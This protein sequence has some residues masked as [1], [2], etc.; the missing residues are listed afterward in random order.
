EALGAHRSEEPLCAHADTSGA[1][2]VEAADQ[3]DPARVVDVALVPV[4]RRDIGARGEW[5]IAHKDAGTCLPG[6]AR[7]DVLHEDALPAAVLALGGGKRIA[8]VER[9]LQVVGLGHH[10]AVADAVIAGEPIHLR[11]LAAAP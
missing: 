4:L 3:N 2:D 11:A 9:A 8:D 7:V 5:P 6:H 10:D 1:R